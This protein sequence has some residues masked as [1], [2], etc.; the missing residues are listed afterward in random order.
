MKIAVLSVNSGKSFLP[1]G[2]M[3]SIATMRRSLRC[4]PTALRAV[5][6]APSAPTRIFVLYSSLDVLTITSFAVRMIV[7]TSSLLPGYIPRSLAVRKSS[8]VKLISANHSKMIALIKPKLACGQ[9][10]F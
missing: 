2:T 6:L 3:L 1:S 7:S 5:L 9:E 8:C 10:K 4:R